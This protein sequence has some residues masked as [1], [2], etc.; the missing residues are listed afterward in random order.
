MLFVL[1]DEVLYG[2]GHKVPN[3]MK[4]KITERFQRFE[5]KFVSALILRDYA[6][7]VFLSNYPNA[8][9]IDNEARRYWVIE[10]SSKFMQDD[11]YFSKLYERM[12]DE[13]ADHFL[14]YLSQLDLS[15]INVRKAPMTKE[16]EQMRAFS[17]TP[18]DAFVHQLLSGNIPFKGYKETQEFFEVGK[19]YNSTM[20]DLFGL[21]Q[22]FG[23]RGEGGNL[24][25]DG[26]NKTAFG[27]QI[28]KKVAI[29]D[30][31]TNRS[32]GT[33]ITLRIEAASK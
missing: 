3:M 30:R 22:E 7:Y 14:T 10:A 32:G 5:E 21:Y 20:A 15:E 4:S 11:S 19:T 25:H 6:N 27:I 1:C 29:Q 23:G 12:D 18:F 26:L 9:K 13:A 24:H 33:P 28:R 2:V 17:M 31:S 16:K 8:V